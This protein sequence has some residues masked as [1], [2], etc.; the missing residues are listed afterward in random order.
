MAGDW[1]KMR[2]DL[3]RDPKVCVIADSLMDS[4]GPLAL[5]VSQISQSDMNVT[6]NV[7]RNA[8]VGSLV[9]VWGV[10]RHR[11][12]RNGDDLSCDGVTIS[13]LDDIAD[14]PGF[15][16]AMA[17]V[18]WVVETPKGIVFP[19]FFAEYNTQPSASPAAERQRRYREKQKENR[20]V[21]RDVTV[22]P[23]VE[24][25]REEKKEQKKDRP[26]TSADPFPGVDPQIVKDFIAIRKAKHAPL[27]DTAIAG[28]KREATKAG[29][30]I[31]EVLTMCCERGWSGFK[32]DWDGVAS[33]RTQAEQKP[34]PRLTA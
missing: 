29:L 6:R 2:T 15:G 1:V 4:A 17:L 28:I 25:S 21:T 18:G 10:M 3:Y 16:D 34:M 7:T 24:K 31:A 13:I 33:R 14:L 20:N 8:T 9:T 12:K 32:A 26:A 19:N 30:S 27:T 11:G 5:Y 23:R 22:T